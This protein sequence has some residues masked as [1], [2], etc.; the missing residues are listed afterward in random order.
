MIIPGI[1]KYL[2]K[3]SKECMDTR[4][5][6]GISEQ[7]IDWDDSDTQPVCKAEAQTYLNGK[8]LTLY[9]KRSV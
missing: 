1:L 6:Q 4:K 7:R 9:I 8:A 5:V 3:V 2:K